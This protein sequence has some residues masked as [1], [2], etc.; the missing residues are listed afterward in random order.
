[1]SRLPSFTRRLYLLATATDVDGISTKSL[2]QEYNCRF[3][4][5]L[6]GFSV[7]D[8]V[9]RVDLFDVDYD[10]N[11]NDK[12]IKAKKTEFGGDHKAVAISQ[13]DMDFE[14]GGERVPI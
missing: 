9:A 2:E 7:Q 11:A 3:G 10:A 6:G 1:M 12:V 14:L 4:T 5:G 13:L 8:A